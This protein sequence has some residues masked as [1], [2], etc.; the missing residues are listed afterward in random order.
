[1][2][3]PAQHE[4]HPLRAVRV[5]LNSNEYRAI[6]GW[7]FPDDPFYVR[8]VPRMLQHDIPQLV[9]FEQCV[10]WGYVDTQAGTDF[11]GFGTVSVSHIYSQYT[12]ALPHFYIPLL[13]VKPAVKSFGY[14]QSIVEHLV[15]EAA[16][17]ALST[18]SDHVFLDVYVSND[19]AVRLYREK[20]G[21]ATLNAN[22][23]ILDPDENDQPYIIM[24]R[25]L[26]VPE[27]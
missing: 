26:P 21:F 27:A 18:L 5:A 11:I 6:Q 14:G 1:M 13:G 15:R 12:N 17:H 8:Q 23:P 3:L 25:K 4:P 7:L 20:C 10:I 2:S 16:N 19:R 9:L 22:S 24:A